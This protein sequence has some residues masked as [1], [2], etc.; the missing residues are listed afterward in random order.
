MLAQAREELLAEGVSVA[1]VKVGIMIEI[2]SVA[3]LAD[4]SPGQGSRLLNRHERPDPVHFGR[5]AWQCASVEYLYTPY[6][7]QRCFD[8]NT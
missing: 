6:Q 3:L 4:W 2:P 1:P 5:R 8:S 7:I